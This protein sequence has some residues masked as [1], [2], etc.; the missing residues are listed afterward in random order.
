M[1]NGATFGALEPLPHSGQMTTAVFVNCLVVHSGNETEPTRCMF[2]VL[3]PIIIPPPL[4]NPA[5]VWHRAITASGRF[6]RI[7]KFEPATLV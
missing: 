2:D 4:E 7:R 5:T 3:S 6:R 1:D